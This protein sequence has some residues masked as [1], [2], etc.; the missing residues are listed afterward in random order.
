MQKNFWLPLI[1]C[2]SLSLSGCLDI[3]EEITIKKDGSGT[4]NLN[5]ISDNNET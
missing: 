1:A 5:K 3:L 2:F 4:F